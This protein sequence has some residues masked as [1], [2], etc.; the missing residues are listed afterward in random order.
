[1]T[2]PDQNADKASAH[3]AKAAK[4][5]PVAAPKPHAAFVK[6]GRAENNKGRK[7]QPAKQ[8]SHLQKGR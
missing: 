4:K 1:M 6:A 8:R 3:R 7:M 2:D 5:K